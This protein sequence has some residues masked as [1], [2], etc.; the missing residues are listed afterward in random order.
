MA[1]VLFLSLLLGAIPNGYS[2]SGDLNLNLNLT[3]QLKESMLQSVVLPSIDT[4]ALEFCGDGTKNGVEECDGTDGVS[5]GQSCSLSC[6]LEY[7]GDRKL[8]PPEEC[9]GTL[10]IT[11]STTQECTDCKIT[12]KDLCAGVTTDDSNACTTDSCDPATGTVTNTAIDGCCTADSDCRDGDKCNGMETCVSNACVDGTA[13]DCNDS[14]DC[15]T[16]S[17]DATAGCTN[18]TIASATGNACGTCGDGILNTGEECDGTATEAGKTCASDCTFV[19]ETD[20]GTCGDGTVD[21]GEEC[22]GTAGITDSTKEECSSECKIV[23]KETSPCLDGSTPTTVFCYGTE[24]AAGETNSG[25]CNNSSNEP[26][27]EIR[28]FT[29]PKDL[30]A[31]RKALL[32]QDDNLIFRTDLATGTTKRIL[33]SQTFTK[34]TDLAFGSTGALYIA[35]AGK[36]LKATPEGVTDLNLS[37]TVERLTFD[38]DG[39]KYLL[40]D[41]GKLYKTDTA[42]ALTL[43]YDIKAELKATDFKPGGR[44]VIF[45][46]ALYLNDLAGNRVLKYD[47]AGNTLSVLAEIKTPVELSVKRSTG[48]LLVQSLDEGTIYKIPLEQAVAGQTS[49]PEVYMLARATGM[50][51]ARICP[52]VKTIEPPCEASTEEC[53]G[54]DNDCDGSVDEDLTEACYTGADG[55]ENVGICAGGTKTCA[56]GAWSDCSGETTPESSD[57]CDDDLDNDCDGTS[58]EGCN[59]TEGETQ[60][61]GSDEGECVAGTQTCA[62]NQWSDDC[63]GETGPSDETC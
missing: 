28:K 43:L 12:K 30:I 59:C 36:V 3:D 7:C 47:L 6:T 31:N 58:D 25:Y 52:P 53:D 38:K 26:A 11:D 62:N 57:T 35:D 18:E 39:N 40:T 4:S 60:S 54:A 16:D 34:I 44:M 61:C 49:T 10:G 5:A 63:D 23:A 29:A 20:T 55:T 24:K 37:I 50:I 27:V 1:F 48:D 46:G 56:N 42:D 9:D 2:Q 8:T 41:E 22:D 51:E 17:C 45:K 15:T 13:L 33:S 19:V 14:N 21:S 32:M